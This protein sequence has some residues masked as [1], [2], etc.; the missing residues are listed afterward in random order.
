M[1]QTVHDDQPPSVGS[2]H[3]THSRSAEMRHAALGYALLAPAI[4]VILGLNL[5]PTLS[6][7]FTSFTDQSLLNPNAWRTVGWQNYQR[8]LTDPVFRVSV[9][10]FAG[11]D[12]FCRY[13]A[14]DFRSGNGSSCLSA[15][16]PV[17]IGF[18]VL[19]WSLWVL[20]I[21][22]AVVIFRFLTLPN[23]GL[24]NIILAALGLGSLTRNWLVIQLSH[25][26]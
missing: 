26:S 11:P 12:F 6:G 15:R 21:I 7:I 18:A 9:Y 13:S 4:C 14:G 8:L 24:I 2:R 16:S 5:Y 3:D 1:S 20:P 17:F 19:P 23:I 10:P 22:T 25:S